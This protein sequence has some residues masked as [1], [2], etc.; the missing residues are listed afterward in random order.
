[1]NFLDRDRPF[2]IA[3]AGTCHSHDNQWGAY[4]SALKYVDA[5][6]KAGADC[7][8]FQIFHRPSPETMFCWIEGD[9]KLVERWCRSCITLAQWWAVCKYTAEQGLCFLAS[10]FQNETVEWLNKLHIEATKVASRAAKDF[11]YAKAPKPYLVSNGMHTPRRRNGIIVM[12]CESKYPSS[13]R[14]SEQHPGFS[15]HSGTPWRAIDAMVRGCKLIEVHF[16]IEPKDAGP[17]LPA[18]LSVDQLR[19]V[20]EARDGLERGGCPPTTPGAV[21]L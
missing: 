16:Y 12:Q 7:I 5:A 18:S 8:K 15:D 9:E 10:T 2:I 17:D 19:S 14:W 1:M 11:P 3:E 13:I 21:R 20:C 4:E 6:Q